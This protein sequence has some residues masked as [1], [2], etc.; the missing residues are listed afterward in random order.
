MT[1]IHLACVANNQLRALNSAEVQKMESNSLVV[2]KEYQVSR[3]IK[4][5]FSAFH[6]VVKGVD[7]GWVTL[8]VTEGVARGKHEYNDRAEGQQLVVEKGLYGFRE[9]PAARAA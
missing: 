8:Q 2:G 3:I 7:M 4:G 9:I 6:A 1:G 5:T